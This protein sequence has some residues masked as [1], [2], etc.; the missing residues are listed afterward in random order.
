MAPGLRCGSCLARGHTARN[1]K[2]NAK[3][4]IP[5]SHYNVITEL[6]K[7]EE[8]LLGRVCGGGGK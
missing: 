1:T 2:Y 5:E 7:S 6:A 3:C 8:M 4:N